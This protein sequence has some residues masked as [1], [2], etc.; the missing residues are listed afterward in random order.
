M[1]P[2]RAV[3]SV[4]NCVGVVEQIDRLVEIDDV[5]AV[6]LGEDVIAHLRVPALLLVPEVNA[7]LEQGLHH[8]TW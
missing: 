6:A 5:D 3:T 7:R 1:R 2:P 8:R 4:T